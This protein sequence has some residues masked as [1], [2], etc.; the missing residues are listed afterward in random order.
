MNRM[1]EDMRKLE[2]KHNL[3]ITAYVDVKGIKETLEEL[4]EENINLSDERILR[5][6]ERSY[7]KYDFSEDDR[8][9]KEWICENIVKENK[10][11]DNEWF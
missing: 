6:I 7:S 8:F 5:I 10:V 2:E 9:F 11:Q 1:Y 3:V 4:E